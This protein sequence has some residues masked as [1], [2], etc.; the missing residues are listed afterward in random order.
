[1][2]KFEKGVYQDDKGIWHVT[3][4]K[5]DV[6]VVAHDEYGNDIED[7]VYVEVGISED[8]LKEMVSLVKMG[9]EGTL[10]EVKDGY[11]YKK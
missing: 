3:Y 9:K 4:E 10:K 6:F 2:K 8:E 11:D 7:E 5:D 1:M